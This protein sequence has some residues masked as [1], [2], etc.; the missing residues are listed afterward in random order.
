MVGEAKEDSGIPMLAFALS[1]FS[2]SIK[3]ES[4][5]LMI[6]GHLRSNKSFDLSP[7]RRLWH[8]NP[9]LDHLPQEHFI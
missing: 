8:S 9:E 3:S 2:F 6:T 5:F 7:P 4:Q 1:L